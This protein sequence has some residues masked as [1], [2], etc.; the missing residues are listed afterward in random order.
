RSRSLWACLL[1]GLALGAVFWTKELAAVVYVALV[2]ALWFFR[3]FVR[4]AV[5]ALAGLLLMLALH[6]WLMWLIAGDPL[7]AVRVVLS[8][9][10]RNFVQGGGGEDSPA[11][12]LRYLFLDVRHVGLLGWLAL[13]GAVVLALPSRPAAVDAAAG[14]SSRAFLWLWAGGLL[15]VLSAFPVSLSPLRFTMKQSNYLS[16]FLAPLSVLAA[17]GL[18]WFGARGRVLLLAV[19]L[20][21]ALLLAALQQADY[22]SFTANSKAVLRTYAGRADVLL[23]GSSNL[24][25]LAPELVQ[26]GLAPVAVTSFRDVLDQPEAE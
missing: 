18:C 17:L 14:P 13:M 24:Q 4:G 23:V 26:L 20:P 12:Y 1:G 5:V 7:H 9:M 2:P 22:R 15:L 16:L 8:S 11:Y 3:R 21:L 6:G 19:G 10:Q 25:G